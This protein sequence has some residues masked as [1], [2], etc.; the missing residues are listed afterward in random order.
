MKKWL[1]FGIGGSMGSRRCRNLQALG[2]TDIVGYDINTES[3]KKAAEKYNIQYVEKLKDLCNYKFDAAIVSVPPLKKQSYIIHCNL[4]GIPCFAEADVT[5]YTGDYCASSTMRHHP[6]IQK[7]K[8]LLDNGALGEIYTFSYVLGQSLYDW[9]PGC[10]MKT[11]YAAQ[12]D[13]GACR[14]MFCFEMSWLSYLFGTPTDATGFVNKR[15]NDPDISAH[16]VY[17]ASVKFCDEKAIAEYTCGMP[18]YPSRH[19]ELKNKFSITGTVLIDIVSRPATRNLRIVGSKCNLLWNWNDDH[20]KLEHPS[21]VILPI[22]YNRGKAAEGYHSA[23]CE[24][25]YISEMRNFID[26]AQGKAEYLF[27]REDEEAVIS[28]LKKIEG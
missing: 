23:I 28:M 16:D 17:T 18:I 22:S 21:G 12:K 6:A 15:M 3:A 13:T 27:S 11:Y 14:E 2:Y 4:E 24:D 20:I 7:I 19:D 10:N 25:M 9:H 8:E 26:A 1:I 5:E